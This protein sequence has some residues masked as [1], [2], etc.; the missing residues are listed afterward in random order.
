[1]IDSF[2]HNTHTYWKK[3]I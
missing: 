2:S 1:M 3:T